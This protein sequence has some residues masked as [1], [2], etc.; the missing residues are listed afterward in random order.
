MLVIKHRL[1]RG[2]GGLTLLLPQVGD[3]GLPLLRRIPPLSAYAYQEGVSFVLP[4]AIGRLPL[5]G[6][7]H[8][9]SVRPGTS[10]VIRI[11]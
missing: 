2:L 6:N 3:R 1:P 11:G 10:R 7:N 8:D 9:L 4:T 5:S